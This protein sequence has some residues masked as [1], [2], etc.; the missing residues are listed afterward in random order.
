MQHTGRATRLFRA[1]LV[2]HVPTLEELG[3]RKPLV[4]TDRDREI[5]S[6]VY[7]HGFLTTDLVQLAFFP[8]A[9]PNGRRSPSS[10]AYDR[11][12]SLWLFSYLERIELP[13]ARSQGGRC[14]SLYALG[15]R[16]VETVAA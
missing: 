16:G 15:R 4:L 12:R 3:K 2:R 6:A 10:K 9:D 8:A 1:G 14:P 11:L 13:M 5:V 7:M